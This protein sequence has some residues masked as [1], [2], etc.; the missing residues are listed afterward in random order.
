M[1]N[2]NT[3]AAL[4]KNTSPIISFSIGMVSRLAYHHVNAAA[5][6][7]DVKMLVSTVF[8]L[9]TS[10]SFLMAKSFLGEQYTLK[11][12]KTYATRNFYML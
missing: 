8:L 6:T 2:I 3:A 4:V 1:H 12:F 11:T 10:I 9:N 7:N 5:T